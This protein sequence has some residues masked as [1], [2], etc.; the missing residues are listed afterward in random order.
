M[1][2]S[3]TLRGVVYKFTGLTGLSSI[4]WIKR[5]AQLLIVETNRIGQMYSMYA[6]I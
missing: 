4:I 1:Q 5:G 3:R 2:F 6:I